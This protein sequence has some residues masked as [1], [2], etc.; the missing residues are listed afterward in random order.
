MGRPRKPAKELK[1]NGTFN[2]VSSRKDWNT[3]TPYVMDQSYAPKRY[4]PE[5]K[6][7][8]NQFMKVKCVQGVLSDEDE[9]M[10][11]LMFDALDDVYRIQAKI[12]EFYNDPNLSANLRDAETRKHLKEMVQVRKIH[13]TSFV[14][15]AVKFGMSPVERSRLQ[16][17][18]S[19]PKSELFELLSERMEG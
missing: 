15:M 19:K 3:D 18:S 14:T 9:A 4:L 7:A 1:L 12:D 10:V 5:T 13:E 8:W 2:K 17:T 16:V 11:I 6:R